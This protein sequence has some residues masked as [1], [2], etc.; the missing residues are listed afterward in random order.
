MPD[1]AVYDYDMYLDPE[2]LRDPH[3]R[4]RGLLRDAPPVFWTPRNNGHWMAVSHSAVTEVMRDW[5]RFSNELMPPEKMSALM[6]MLPADFPHIPQPKPIT[7]DPPSHT[8]YRS[9]LTRAFAPKSMMALS[10]QIQTLAASLIDAVVDDGHC[11]FI[12]AVAEPLPVLVFLKMMG[13]PQDRLGEF[14]RLVH[15][16]MSPADDES[17]GPQRMRMIADAIKDVIVARRD[18]PQDDLISLLWSSEIDGEPMTMEV[19]EDFAVLLFI[20][21][22]DTVINAIGFAVRHMA[23]HPDMQESLRADQSRIVETVEEMLRRYSI[24]SPPRRVAKDTE[25][26][27]WSLKRNDLITPVLPGAMLDPG[28]WPS[29]ELVD[30]GREDR[31]HFTFGAGPHRC[32][33]SHL[34]RIELQ[35]LY[36]EV[37]NRLPPFRLDPDKPAVFGAG[38]IFTVASLPIRWD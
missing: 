28:H 25:L 18:D 16:M 5:E 29:P 19:M 22:L 15:V 2:L 23:A 14:R 26:A 4:V 30:I 20:A 17:A 9:A 34:A 1:A 12:T 11:D 37:L 33:G 35:T 13:L 32:L 24:V 7:L 36:G 3:E 38:V 31:A 6:A 27:G 10:D 8:K 21:G